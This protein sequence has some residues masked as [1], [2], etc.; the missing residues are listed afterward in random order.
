MAIRYTGAGVGLILGI[1]AAFALVG[2]VLWG[3]VRL[4]Q[5]DLQTGTGTAP[6][7]RVVTAPGS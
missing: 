2:L 5:A 1:V 7:R 3:V 4:V 6:I